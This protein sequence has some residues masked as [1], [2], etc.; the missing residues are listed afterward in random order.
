[1]DDYVSAEE[2]CESADAAYEAVEGAVEAASRALEEVEGACKDPPEGG[3]VGTR[4]SH[5]A[6][7]VALVELH[8]ALIALETI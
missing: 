8:D 3:A 2:R 4:I 6:V 1:M 7:T 5:E